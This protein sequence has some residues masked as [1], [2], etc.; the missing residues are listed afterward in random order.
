MRRRATE[1]IHCQRSAFL[2]PG[3][4]LNDAAPTLPS[5]KINI[6]ISGDRPVTQQQQQQ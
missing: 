1:T 6:S 5:I 3:I 2:P 4:A